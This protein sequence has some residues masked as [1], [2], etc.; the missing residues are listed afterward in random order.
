MDASAGHRRDHDAPPTARTTM[1]PIRPT[2]PA[3]AWPAW[4]IAGLALVLSAAALADDLVVP[5]SGNPEYVLGQLARAFNAR[6]QRHRVIV[7]PSSGTAGAI[8]DVGENLSSLGRV[9]RP[10]KDDEKAK[11]L[12]YLPIGREPVVVVAGA[13]VDVKAIT[14]AQVADIYAGRITNWRELGG[15]SAPIRAIGREKTDASRLALERIVLPLKEV[16]FPG[17]I[18]VVH[19]DTQLI[20]LLDRYPTSLGFLNRSALA[21]CT[22]KVVPLILD[23]VEPT[24]ANVASGRYAAVLEFGLIHGPG[25]PGNAGRAFIEF[26]RSAEGKNILHQHGVSPVGD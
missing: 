13:G 11:G 4:A 9:G 1:S 2:S 14:S 12:G 8:R 3:G 10:L 16:S 20:A 21:A 25:G 22:T 15:R 26:I 5:G 18:K 19:L 17:T 6:Q 23:G 24:P 7:P